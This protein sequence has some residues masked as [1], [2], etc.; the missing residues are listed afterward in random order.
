MGFGQRTPL[1]MQDRR[2]LYKLQQKKFWIFFS[3]TNFIS[4]DH[5]C[6]F[7]SM[8]KRSSPISGDKW[9]MDE[10]DIASYQPQ[11]YDMISYQPQLYDM[12]S[13][14]PQ[15]YDNEEGNKD[16]DTY[17]ELKKILEGK[18]RQT[19]DLNQA[20]QSR[21]A[22]RAA[23]A[24]KTT[25]HVDETILRGF[26]FG[27]LGKRDVEWPGMI[28]HVGTQNQEKK[29]S[30]GLTE[31][32]SKQLK[33]RNG[34]NEKQGKR[35]DNVDP[36]ETDQILRGF[37]FGQLGKRDPRQSTLGSNTAQ[38]DEILRGFSFGQLGKRSA[39]PQEPSTVD[40]VL[41]GFSFGQLGKRSQVNPTL[42][43]AEADQILRG[44]SFGQ[45]GKRTA[46]EFSLN[47]IAVDQLLGLFKFAR[48]IKRPE[49]AEASATEAYRNQEPVMAEDWSNFV[50]LI[51]NGESTA[52]PATAA[53]RKDEGARTDISEKDISLVLRGFSF[54][55]MGRRSAAG[56]A[57][58]HPAAEK[59]FIHGNGEL[60]M[61]GNSED[62]ELWDCSKEQEAA[63]MQQQQQQPEEEQTTPKSENQFR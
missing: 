11:L 22:K 62:K 3:Q 59:R 52:T 15:W 45:L 54:G 14:Q 8:G 4:F 31:D 61:L 63:E 42:S 48:L 36:A 40:D 50:R 49:L 1:Q 44:F 25:P 10:E 39:T 26:S 30:D 12:T 46:D 58:L 32:D 34:V 29:N 2:N 13:Y 35:A 27:Q 18:E 37:S 7:P 19:N 56:G 38:A 9:I 60:M 23:T 41:R 16:A 6:S 33:K 53:P 28:G 21:E 20:E 43:P 51:R 47:P 5:P 55:Q 17:K 57:E 24:A